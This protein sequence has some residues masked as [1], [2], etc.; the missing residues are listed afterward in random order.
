[1][2]AQQLPSG[3][4]RCRVYI[5]LD[6]NGKSKY[7]TF[8]DPDKK[9]CEALAS[10]FADRGKRGIKNPSLLGAMNEFLSLRKATLSP[11]TYKEYKGYVKIIG[12]D[13]EAL[14]ALPV[15]SITTK[16]IQNLVN[17][18]QAK[19]RSPK[20]IKN[21][22]GFISSVLDLQEVD[23]P[24]YTLPKTIKKDPYIPS[25]EEVRKVIEI[26]KEKKPELVIP[27]MLAAFASMRR[28][29]ICALKWP[30][31]FKGNI[32]TINKDMVQ[33]DNLN[34]IVKTTKTDKSTRRV[35]LPDFVVDAIREKGYITTMNPNQMT[36]EFIRLVRK[37]GIPYFTLHKLRHYSASVALGMG[38]PLTIVADRGGWEPGSG[39]LQ[40]IY[41]HVLEEQKN[42]ETEKINSFF[43]DNFTGNP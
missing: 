36:N 11:K 29:E 7:K 37:S 24:R 19:G 10:A 30:D 17:Q 5:G 32:V 41:T 23:M 31:D 9:H 21:Y 16:H 12:K 18:M 22:C 13:Y 27:A 1:M 28:S 6:E 33:D 25:S 39:V 4:W 35:T 20:T 14:S 34:W 3:S 43:S 38:I 8:V 2:N 26:M 42:V 40:R 15:R